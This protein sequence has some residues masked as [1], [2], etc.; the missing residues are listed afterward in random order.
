ML[1]IKKLLEH[2][3]QRGDCPALQ[4]FQHDC[5][6]WFTWQELWQ[7][8]SKSAYGLQNLG[9]CD[10]N[11]V[12]ISAE[13][14]W[15]WIIA[16]LAC[17]YLRAVSVPLSTQL[18]SQQLQSQIRHSG[19]SLL[20]IDDLDRL[21]TVPV[22]IDVVTL[23]DEPSIRDDNAHWTVLGSW[24][25]I[26]NLGQIDVK[27]EL[28]SEFDFDRIATIIY[29]SGTTGAPKGVMLSAGNLAFDAEQTLDRYGFDQSDHQYCFLP[30]FHAFART[31][32][33][34]AWIVGGH[35]LT[36]ASDRN[37][38]IADLTH[39]QPTHINGVPLYFRRLR[40]AV[41][42][43]DSGNSSVW[44]S[45][46]NQVNSGGAALDNATFD[47][48]EE[49]G[50]TMLEGYGLTETSPVATLNSRTTQRRGSA[51]KPLT[52]TDVR[53]SEVGEIQIAGPH[54]FAGYFRDAELTSTTI[55]DGWFKTGDLG[56]IDDDGFLFVTGRLDEMIVTTVGENIWPGLLE[57][58]LQEHAT[59]EQVMV[60]GHGCDYLVALVHPNWE[61]FVNR[62]DLSGGPAVWVD[63]PN[64]EQWFHKVVEQQLHGF[65]PHEQIRKVALVQSPWTWENDMLTPKGTLRR[66]Q[67]A[68]K[69]DSILQAMYE[70]TD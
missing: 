56:R 47:F 23:F 54:V 12:G 51:G 64:V 52:E 65:A 27:E 16:D 60:Y 42:S 20:I 53:I 35:R 39:S 50:I 10:G 30:L 29:T 57:A 1:L 19:M 31:C 37:N 43:A 34:Y 15:Q 48:F 9:V 24:D 63:S 61:Q 18:S 25:E 8:V 4:V 62:L 66:S 3:K 11:R 7:Q 33:L 2:V 67:I 21:D 14:C 26:I 38:A 58:E 55:E 36:L 28:P 22:A 69:F 70:R 46:L 5:W 40:E 17:Q 68:A 44:G 32:D 13:N 41:G 59:I 6:T 45:R 49:H